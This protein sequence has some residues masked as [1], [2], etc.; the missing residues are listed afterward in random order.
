MANSLQLGSRGPGVSA[1]QAK[2]NT[3]LMPSPRLVA[4]GAF[5]PKTAQAVKAFQQANRLV[6]D[7]V[8]G[9]KTAAALGLSLGGPSGPAP[10]GFV[11]P[12]APPPPP[13]GAP[14]KAGPP[15]FVDLSVFNVVIEEIIGGFQKIGARLISWI[16]SDYVPQFVY[17]R[18]ESL[19]NG[20]VN[21][22]VAPLRGITRQTVPLGQDPAAFVTDRIRTVVA[23]GASNISSALQPLVGLPVIGGVASGYQR[24]ISGLM[25]TV[26]GALA[27]LRQNGQAAQATATAKRIA[28][29]F[30]AVARQIG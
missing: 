1:L 26:D 9:P 25:T 2:L 15:G 19:V 21:M 29:E 11:A 6:A 12:G 10:G 28:A 8:V 14:P 7:G 5:G 13:G 23:R 4:D 22:V 20:G 18:V 30:D 16:D 24:K 3:V 27:N 17:D